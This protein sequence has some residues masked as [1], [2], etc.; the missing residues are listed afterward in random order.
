MSNLSIGI[1]AARRDEQTTADL[2]SQ[3]SKEAWLR[4]ESVQHP[5]GPCLRVG[6]HAEDHSRTTVRTQEPS[7]TTEEG[8]VK[9]E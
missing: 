1:H 9:F 7:R 4:S 2:A 5:E 3:K 8:E 6:N